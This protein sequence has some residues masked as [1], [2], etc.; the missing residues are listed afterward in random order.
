MNHK[1]IFLAFIVGFALLA[2]SGAAAKT[3]MDALPDAG[4]TPDSAFY[5]FDRLGDWARVNVFFFSPARKARAM[6]DVAEERLAE[7]K[8]MAAKAPE[9]IE[10]IKELRADAD[11]MIGRANSA[12]DNMGENK[13]S[14]AELLEKL[15]KLSLKRQ[16]AIGRA[17]EL[18]PEEVREE[19]EESLEK[20]FELSEK[21]RELMMKQAE[22]GIISRE[23]FGRLSKE[24]AEGLKR[25]AQKMRKTAEEADERGMKD[26]FM[27][28]SGRNLDVLEG[29]IFSIESK[30]DLDELKEEAAETVKSAIDSLLEARKEI[31]EGEDAAEDALKELRENGR[32]NMKERAEEMIKKAV[33]RIS[34]VEEKFVG[35]EEDASRLAARAKI[36]LDG[37]AGHLKT[38]KTAF[39]KEKY[40]EAFARSLAAYRQARAA[41]RMAERKV[42]REMGE[43][44]RA[45]EM[46]P[47]EMKEFLKE[48]IKERGTEGMGEMEEFLDKMPDNEMKEM[49]EEEM[50]G[51][52][53]MPFFRGEGEKRDEE[54]ERGGGE[55]PGPGMDAPEVE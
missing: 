22:E 19:L 49:M 51:M 14:A 45:S 18:V 13:K 20:V 55:L 47:A 6:A 16:A 10:I 11:E 46:E 1:K 36:M 7:L 12:A 25:M 33:E 39:V 44:E 23:D 2:S 27:G 21:R 4:I 38:A 35:G 17:I 26:F 29:D 42:Q 15:D 9:K 30:G 31:S 43:F 37:A 32:L 5:F 48:K 28:M 41:E 40:G 54:N 50:D 3:D 24:R 8:E 53:K 52:E 34:E